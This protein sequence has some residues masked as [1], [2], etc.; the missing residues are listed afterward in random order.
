VKFEVTIFHNLAALTRDHLTIEHFLNGAS[1]FFDV[2]LLVAARTLLAGPVLKTEVADENFTINA[3]TL[4][5]LADEIF[6]DLANKNVNR[7]QI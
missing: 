4:H 7:L 2:R 3:C 1:N 5:G 6:A